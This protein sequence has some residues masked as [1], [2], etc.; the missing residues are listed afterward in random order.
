[1]NFNEQR[2]QRKISSSVMLTI[3]TSAGKYLS[4]E[5]SGALSRKDLMNYYRQ[6]DQQFIN[7]GKLHLMVVVTG[8]SG[9]AGPIALGTMLLN[10]HKVMR[11]VA[12]YAAVTDQQWFKQLIAVLNRMVPNLRMKAFSTKE[13][14][15]AWLK[16]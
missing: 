10:E 3:T 15:T 8:F 6:L 1:M 14:A 12:R 13:E 7:A 4:Y 2:L 5:V 16:D 9:Y 11:K